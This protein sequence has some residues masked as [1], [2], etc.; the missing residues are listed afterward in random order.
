MLF[1]GEAPVLC[2]SEAPSSGCCCGD[3][4]LLLGGG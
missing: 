1:R 2:R 4:T 3:G